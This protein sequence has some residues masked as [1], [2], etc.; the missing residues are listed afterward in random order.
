VEKLPEAG[1]ALLA[2]EECSVSVMKE[3][4]QTVCKR[5]LA[6]KLIS[7]LEIDKSTIKDKRNECFAIVRKKYK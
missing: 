1:L 4:G 2:L 3:L 7:K 5:C 6:A